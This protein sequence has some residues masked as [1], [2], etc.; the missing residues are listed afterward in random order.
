MSSFA[1]DRQSRADRMAESAVV[2]DSGGADS[3]GVVVKP[4][5]LFLS[6]CTGV[7][8]ATEAA[9]AAAAAASNASNDIFANTP[10]AAT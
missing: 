2:A 4:I 9:A 6:Q 5:G 1:S 7:P 8:D 3:G 10:D